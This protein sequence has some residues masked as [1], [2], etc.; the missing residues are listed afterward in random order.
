MEEN[1]HFFLSKRS[2]GYTL[3]SLSS[4]VE[5]DRMCQE[6]ELMCLAKYKENCMVAE[7]PL[8]PP[9]KTSLALFIMF[10]K[11]HHLSGSVQPPPSLP[12]LSSSTS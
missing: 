6:G 12:W 2:D 9:I 8:S 11:T 5:D 10:A 7:T 1:D 4:V 3:Y